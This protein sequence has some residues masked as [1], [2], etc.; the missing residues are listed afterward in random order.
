[1]IIGTAID[2]GLIP[3]LLST[4]NIS[5]PHLDLLIIIFKVLLLVVH[6]LAPPHS[7][8]LLVHQLQFLIQSVLLICQSLISSSHFPPKLLQFT[9]NVLGG[10]LNLNKILIALIIEFQNIPQRLNI[11]T[12]ISQPLKR[13]CLLLAY[14]QLC[15]LGL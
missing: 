5:V 10:V 4:L 3:V 1:M 11:V 6:I 2:L 15:M 7:L 8:Y 9:Q 12:D 13:R 14:L